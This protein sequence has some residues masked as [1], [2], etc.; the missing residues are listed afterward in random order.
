MEE[1]RFNTIE[2]LYNKLLPALKTK[3]H[4][5]ERQ[6]IKYISEKDIWNYLTK[7]YWQKSSKLTLADMV[8]DILSTPDFELENYYANNLKDQEPK[9]ESEKIL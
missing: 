5:L 8:N 3:K 1:F 6:N 2:Q 7:N 9:S 4:D